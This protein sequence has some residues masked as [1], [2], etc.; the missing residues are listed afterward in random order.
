MSARD[1]KI[2][3]RVKGLF[4]RNYIDLRKVKHQTVKGVVYISGKLI[5]LRDE[6][7][8]PQYEISRLEREIRKIGE[9]EDII[10][11]VQHG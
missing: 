1:M 8:V 4:V 7:P 9:V 11:N 5:Y 3:L 10:W 6:K 2:D